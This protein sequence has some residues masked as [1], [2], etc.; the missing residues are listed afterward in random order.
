MNEETYQ[1]RVIAQHGEIVAAIKGL[2]NASEQNNATVRQSLDSM[3]AA[4]T[5][6]LRVPVSLFLITAVSWLFY[7]GKI[8]E[9]T[10]TF[11][12]LIA[13]FPLFGDSIRSVIEIFR[14]TP[15]K[16]ERAVTVARSLVIIGFLISLLAGCAPAA[17]LSI[18]D[19]P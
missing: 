1:Q 6:A 14:G 15:E 3:R 7:M 4:L 16:R 8:K 17:H 12:L 10:W 5:S 9:S 13:I 11:F 2:H 18:T 19:L